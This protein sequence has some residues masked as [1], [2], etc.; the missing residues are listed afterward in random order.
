[1]RY[2]FLLFLFSFSMQISFSQNNQ[3]WKGYFSYNSITDVAQSDNR[4]YA[5]SEN[6][7]FSKSTLTNEVK[8]INTIDGL[9][10]Q[11]ISSLY[12][13]KAFNKT[14]IG[15]KNGLMIVIN[16]D[17][18]IITVV[19]I[20]NKQIPP[21]I[22]KVNHFNEHE[23]IVY[24]SC[25]FGIVQYNLTTLQF[26]DTY[27]IGTGITEIVVNQTAILNGYIY[28][29]TLTEGLKRAELTNP[30]LIDANE[31]SVTSPG[32]FLNVV[33]FENKLFT[34]NTSGQ[35][36]QS[37]NGVTFSNF[38]PALAPNAVD[39]R[40]T[41]TELI[42]TTPN[43][44]F[45]Y[46]EQLVQM[47]R[48]DNFLIP[49]ITA[50]FTCATVI[51]TTLYIGTVEDG[52]LTTAVENPTAFETISPNGPIK[53]NIFSINTSSSNLWA[54]YGGYDQSLDPDP[55]QFFGISK[56]SSDS[57]W[58][59]IPFSEVNGASNLVRVTVNPANEEQIFVS[60]YFSGLLKFENDVL[61][62][63]FNQTNTGNDGLETIFPT[64][65]PEQNIRVE[66]SAYDSNGN[67]WMTNAVIKDPLKVMK[68][69]GSW[70]SYNMENILIDYFDARFMKLVIDKNNTKW[71]ATRSDGLIGFNENFNNGEFRKIFT[72]AD[73]GNLPSAAV[74][75]VAIDKRNQMWI[76]TRAGLRI[77]SSVDRF[78]SGDP[79][80][81]FFIVIEEEE[82]GAELLDDQFITDIVVDGANNKWIGTLDA[83]VF[84][85]SPNGQE[86]IHQF[87]SANSP[88][89]SNSINDIDI[90]SATG[91]VFFA[92]TGGLVSFKGNAIN[93]SDDLNN[94]VVY[95][96][97]V[98][99]EYEGTVKIT[100]LLDKANIKITDIE[101]NLV[102][103]TISQ[104]GTIEWDTR[105]FGKYKVAS[106]VYM[107]FIAAQDGLETKVKKV[108]I[109]R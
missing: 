79:L 63:T 86:T 44:I 49:E 35:V 40:A 64:D 29:A 13:S 81:T 45:I 3:L 19:D 1:M 90:N 101:G 33:T 31:W 109:I 75:A 10:S 28:A 82:T 50:N 78:T 11:E 105:A 5:S 52:V 85:F 53:N 65:P 8:T 18:T 51:G 12:F 56:L 38:G 71:M 108:M 68:A 43:T 46:N 83:G 15:Y 98:R 88:L 103:E 24:I 41:N 25:D 14:L 16:A 76:G 36:S 73:T 93:P 91:E 69:G 26:G 87:T 32:S 74:Q 4:F 17:G 97:P 2:L 70:Q 67:L 6:A 84:L 21:N 59:N 22:K 106:G 7:I 42:I 96:N 39:M 66:Q 23:G 47:A 107:I 94:V 57:G 102:Y 95:P 58:L 62:T 20:L 34:I 9:P 72:G 77:L 48:V 60:S 30:N 80:N 61:V 99:P 55:L 92:T 104:G 27:F 54:V 89:P 37:T 100:G